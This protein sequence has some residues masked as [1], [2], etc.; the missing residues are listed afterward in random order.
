MPITAKQIAMARILLDLSQK[1]LANKLGMARK[2]VMRL[3]NNQSPGST[4]TMD[5]IQ[6][7]FENNGLEFLTNNGVQESKEQV[8]ILNGKEGLR[9]LFDELYYTARDKGGTLCLFNGMPSKLHEWLGDEWYKMHIARMEKIKNNFRY[10]IIVKKGEPS[11]PAS[12]YATYKF[13][14]EKLF[15]EKTIYVL[16][17]AVFFRDQN[18]TSLKHIRLEQ[19]EIANSIRILFD[20]AWHKA[21]TDIPN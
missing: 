16:G 17:D 9:A 8:K 7:Y 20:I 5:K 2:T 18:D 12:N 21:A 11:L 3:E 13:F 14:P 6:T 1:D 19:P 4:K 15:N 10:N